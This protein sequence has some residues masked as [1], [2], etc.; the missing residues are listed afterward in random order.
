MR[1]AQSSLA[2]LVDG[3]ER[4]QAAVDSPLTLS[5][6]LSRTGLLTYPVSAGDLAE[7]DQL[8]A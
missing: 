2:P 5:P 7:F 4:R 8:S 3:R 6:S 1:T